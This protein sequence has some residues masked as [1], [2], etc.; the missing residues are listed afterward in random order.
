MV[1]M[2]RINWKK[3]MCKKGA[4]IFVLNNEAHKNT[5]L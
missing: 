4:L 2:Y 1:V 5:K 3:I